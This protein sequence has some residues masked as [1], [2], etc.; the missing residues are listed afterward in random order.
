MHCQGPE[1][2]IGPFHDFMRSLQ[3]NARVESNAEL[4]EVPDRTQ[5]FEAKEVCFSWGACFCGPRVHFPLPQAITHAWP[6]HPPS[7]PIPLAHPWP[8][9][10]VSSVPLCV[11]VRPEDL[12]KRS[13]LI[14]SGQWVVQEAARKA[15]HAPGRALLPSACTEAC[16]TCAPQLAGA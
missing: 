14:V 16:P 8:T 9:F 11:Q 10:A 1:S 4:W 7:H 5:S 2:F 6:A 13:V 15:G 12:G 3:F